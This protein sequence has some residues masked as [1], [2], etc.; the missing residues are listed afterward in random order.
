MILGAFTLIKNEA[1]WVGFCVLAA[2]NIV[3]EWVFFDGNSTDGTIEILEYLRDKKG[4]P[5]KLFKG[6]DPKDLRDDYVRIFNDCL[7]QVKSQYAWFLHP[8]MILL[9]ARKPAIHPGPLCFSV[10]LRSFAGE[11]NGEILEYRE[12]R[13][14]KW[15]SIMRNALGLHYH[16]WYGAVDEDMYFKNITGNQ[17][18]AYADWRRCPF[19]IVESGIELAHYSDVRPYARRSGRMITCLENQG[20]TPEGAREFAQQHPRVTLKSGGPFGRFSFSP[21]GPPPAIFGEHA[22]ELATVI[23]KKPEDF[24][25]IPL[26]VSCRV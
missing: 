16:G 4:L 2:K 10:E 9:K 15:K 17:Y 24:C 5:I 13:M 25:P 14:P 7:G 18:K 11:P 3:D 19:D 26:E 1:P 12:G 21:A 8:D 6:Q 23:G 22:T 20:H